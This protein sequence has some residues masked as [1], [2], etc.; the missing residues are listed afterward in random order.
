[1]RFI[2]VLISVWAVVAAGSSVAQK[3]TGAATGAARSGVAETVEIVGTLIDSKV[4]AC[5]QTTGRALVGAHLILDGEGGRRVN[6]HLGPLTAVESL[7]AQVHE[8]TEV[9]TQAFRTD[10][11]APN[12][13]AAITVTVDGSTTTLRGADLRPTW[14]ATLPQGRGMNAGR[15]MRAGTAGDGGCWWALPSTP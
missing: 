6:L 7:L 14:A 13:Y 12:A 2:A 5:P 4:D 11:M 8:G 10:A 1:M 15:G 9:A 3:G